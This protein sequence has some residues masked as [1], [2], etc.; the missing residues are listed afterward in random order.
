MY[1]ERQLERIFAKLK[2][3]EE[4]LEP[5]LFYTVG[6]V[7][8]KA[9]QTDGSHHDVPEESCFAPCEDGTAFEG[10]GIYCWFQGD[11]TV[12]Q[13]L[14]G[15]RLF[16]YP[17]IRGY[18]GMLWVNGKPYG[19]YA[20]K[21]IEHSHGNH[22]CDMLCKEAHGGETIQM[23]FE[24]YANH[25]IKGTQPFRV[26]AQK[27][28]RIVYHPVD[29]CLKDEELAE[30][31]FDLKVANQMVK[32]LEKK[33][34]RRAAFVR[35]MLEI[36]NLISYDFESEDTEVFRMQMHR[37]D[38]ILKKVL[39]EKNSAS[40]PYAGLIGHSHMDTAWLWHRGET[41]K[42][43]ARTYANQMNLMDQYPE[44]TFVQSSAYHSEIIKKM[45]PA[46]FEDIKKRVA[47]GRYEPNGGV[48]VE[49]D[50][51]IPSG[52]YMIRQ[53][54][55]GQK[56]TREN[57][58]YTSDA[59]WLPDTFGYSASLPQIMQGCEI[60][61]FLTTKMAWNDT[62][63]FPYDTFYWKGI[64]GSRVLVHF[65]R[66]HVWPDPQTLKDNLLELGDNTIKERA[67]SNMRLISYGFGDGGGGPEFGMIEMARRLGD[68]EEMPRTSHTTVSCFMQELEQSLTEASTYNGELYLELHRGTLTNQHVI[69]RNNRKA[70]LALRDLEYVTVVDAVR[71]GVEASGEQIDPLTS[72]ML[73]N[74]FHDILPGTC[75]PR[76]HD[77]AIEAVSHIIE[78]AGKQTAGLLESAAGQRILEERFDQGNLKESLDQT[79]DMTEVS[80]TITLVNTLSS[81]RS[82]VQYLP[83]EGLYVSGGYR[84]QVIEDM[85]GNKKLAVMGVTI[86]A[87]GSK[88]LT[89]T[90]EHAEEASVFSYGK[91][92]RETL[93][94]P[95]VR[96][97]FNEK[98]YM[99][100]FV[101]KRNGREL[102]GEGYALNTLLM[103]HE[104][105]SSWDN[106]DVDADYESK[107]RDSAEIL[108]REV[109]SD[110]A[111]EFRIRSRY[112]LSERSTLDQDMIFHADSP[113][114][115][116]ETRM[117]WQEEHRFLKAA[118]D[119]NIHTDYASHEI[120][121]GYIRRTT[122]RNTEI[123]KAR[124]EVSNHKYTDLSETRYG[125]ALLNDCKY[126][127]SVK[128]SQM[129][130][131][132]HK[133]GC[134]PDYRGDKGIHECTYA[135]L[136]HMGSLS[137]ESV[138][139]PAYQLNEK[140]L[141]V[142]GSLSP[143]ESLVS[144]DS[145]HV[146]VETVKP[147]EEKG[148]GFILRLYEAE[149]AAD[150]VTLTFGFPVKGLAETNMLEETQQEYEAARQLTLQFRAFEIKTLRVEY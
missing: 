16:V 99:E 63:V 147:M 49:C 33:S 27:Y 64:D 17:G 80:Q 93:E 25:Y 51:N 87:F 123:E 9:F 146:I 109:V 5:K 96:V 74:Q 111:V 142:K 20:A 115:I 11:Y 2:W 112:R 118:F 14:D 30:F 46:L 78:E 136:P 92:G 32:V 97:I 137:A 84:Q 139:W 134:M 69:K 34:F 130:L 39:Q 105:S 28:Y 94:T 19:N 35:A 145:P 148:R 18:E 65:N 110:G 83:F 125:A 108:F 122:N 88:V 45:Y 54:V 131:S 8:M 73:I 127:I 140:P 98:G 91:G 60:K 138:I 56:F 23:A 68:C 132:L 47:E 76:A 66:T 61:Y 106:W 55:W 150:T 149:G 24:Y 82:D 107:F 117:N 85:D 13:E 44:Y 77:E 70:E 89:L 143:A 42:K 126:G 144:V 3:L 38:A 29:I 121:F 75:I 119:T 81:D 90:K 1:T 59:F 104:V 37:A 10:E 141:A 133:G 135:F 52:E 15:K 79:R 40:A 22:Y 26:E 129:R 114:V 120:Q 41:E 7:P 53:F 4:R 113:E 101:D 62:N 12:P 31:Y 57:F 124:F 95:M 86:P 50:C 128:D 21:F 67:V 58:N 36:H 103:A 6:T 100:S 72:E 43:C 48:Y 102:K 116:F 71:R